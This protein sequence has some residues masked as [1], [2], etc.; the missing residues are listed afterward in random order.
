MSFTRYE[1]RPLRFLGIR[2][3]RGLK[4]KVYSIVYG[5]SPLRTP[6]FEAGLLLAERDLPH[7]PTSAQRPGVGFIIMHQ[8]RTA[9]YLIMCWWDQENELPLRV[10]V[11]DGNGWRPAVGGESVCIWDLRVIWWER[12][13]V[14][15]D[16]SVGDY[17]GASI[18]GFA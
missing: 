10:Y 13:T 6:D 12:E 3:C 7:P 5:E 1:P 16:G 18:S 14:L 9:D 15:S 8:G 2:D 4:L 17:L 11:R